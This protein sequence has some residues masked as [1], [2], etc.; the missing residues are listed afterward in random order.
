MAWAL[1]GNIHLCKD[2]APVHELSL[3]L[4][5]TKREGEGEKYRERERT[6]EGEGET[7]HGGEREEIDGSRHLLI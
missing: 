7:G 6:G 3:V 2:E 5:E 1:F 4:A